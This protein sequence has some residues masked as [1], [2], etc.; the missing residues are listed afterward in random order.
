MSGAIVDRRQL[1][2]A[3]ELLDKREPVMAAVLMPRSSSWQPARSP[4]LDP[5]H[6]P[7]LAVRQELSEGYGSPAA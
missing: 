6:K 3:A 1:P 7:P 4:R 5:L 2:V